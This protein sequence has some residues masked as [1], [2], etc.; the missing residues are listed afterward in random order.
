MTYTCQ[1]R[2]VSI[3]IKVV[4]RA[5]SKMCPALEQIM[6]SVGEDLSLR[7]P[8]TGIRMAPG[9]DAT[10]STAPNWAP[11]P[12]TRNTSHVKATINA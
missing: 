12:A 11:E 8:P 10:A 6:M 9:T 1:S 5:N 3:R 7:T 4:S 2:V